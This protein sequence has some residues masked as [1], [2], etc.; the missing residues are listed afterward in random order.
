[1]LGRHLTVGG[2]VLPLSDLP[3]FGQTP[4]FQEE[5]LALFR[6]LQS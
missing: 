2:A 3:R 5:D 4:Y 1:M 6:E